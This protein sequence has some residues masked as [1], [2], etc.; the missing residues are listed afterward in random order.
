MLENTLTFQ[1]EFLTI[2]H[3]K[4]TPK[5]I[6]GLTKVVYSLRCMHFYQWFV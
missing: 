5:Y 2:G 4:K 3:Q 6:T 1:Q